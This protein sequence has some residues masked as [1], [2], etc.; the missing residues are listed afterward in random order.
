MVADPQE[1]GLRNRQAHR[2]R[3]PLTLHLHPP[4]L[5]S[6]EG[7]QVDEAAEDYSRERA[8]MSKAVDEER[9][10]RRTARAPA[11]RRS[12]AAEEEGTLLEETKRS[13]IGVMP[14]TTIAL[15]E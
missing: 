13:A 14:S 8:R 10:L 15:K 11:A 4:R 1:E 5:P 3:R 6:E 2:P 7:A 12:T 9:E